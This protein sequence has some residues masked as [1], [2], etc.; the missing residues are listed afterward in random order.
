MPIDSN[1]QNIPV[2][3]PSF[4]YHSTTPLQAEDTSLSSGNVNYDLPLKRSTRCRKQP[5]W[6]S[7]FVVNQV[8]IPDCHIPFNL[9]P[10][11]FSV[12][13]VNFLDRVS[14]IQES[15]TFKQASQSPKWVK[16]MGEE[17]KA[18]EKNQT[19]ELTSLP[20]EKKAIGSKWVY[21]VK[22]RAYRSVE[23]FKARL[24]AKG[25][26]QIQGLDYHDV[27]SPVAKKRHSQNYTISSG[28]EGLVVTPS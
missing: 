11:N 22:L 15:W 18:L 24:V 28:R 23:R 4:S 8:S 27:F 17:L 16:A 6:L 12:D 25:Y 20:K 9:S 19:W 5:T 3:N 7:D 14:D 21:K 26:N 13:H 2:T 10:S 1:V